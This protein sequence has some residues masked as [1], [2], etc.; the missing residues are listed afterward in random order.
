MLPDQN[1]FSFCLHIFCFISFHSGRGECCHLALVA[2][3]HKMQNP[4]EKKYSIFAWKL[5]SDFQRKGAKSCLPNSKSLQA[6]AATATQRVHEG[7]PKLGWGTAMLPLIPPFIP[8]LY[9]TPL[10]LPTEQKYSSGAS[11]ALCDSWRQV[12]LHT[13]KNLKTGWR[14]LIPA[15]NVHAAQK[16]GRKS[17]PEEVFICKGALAEG[18]LLGTPLPPQL[19]S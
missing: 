6:H 5:E 13:T 18:T 15:P 7:P 16:L 1:K 19:Y 10:F 3:S 2:T 12:P 11:F 9:S 4:K 14:P 17:L 8:P